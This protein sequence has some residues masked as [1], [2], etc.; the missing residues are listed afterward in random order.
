MEA[1]CAKNLCMEASCAKNLCM[2]ASC[3]KNLFMEASCT[4]KRELC[5][6]E[7]EG[8]KCELQAWGARFAG[9]QT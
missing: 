4:K 2:E 5:R 1:S 9:V 8:A 3:A 6:W 7:R